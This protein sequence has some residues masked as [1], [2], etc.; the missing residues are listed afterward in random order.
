MEPI[1]AAANFASSAGIET[2]SNAAGMARSIADATVCAEMEGCELF[3][4]KWWGLWEIWLEP[5]DTIVTCSTLDEG[6]VVMPSEEAGEDAFESKASESKG[7]LIGVPMVGEGGGVAKCLDENLAAA[8][9]GMT[10]FT[11]DVGW[12]EWLRKPEAQGGTWV[13]PVSVGVGNCWMSFS[14]GFSMPGPAATLSGDNA[15]CV[16]GGGRL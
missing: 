9:E 13:D 4:Y 16:Y 10:G 11:G 12:N 5:A 14:D 1:V 7:P 3:A 15:V 6:G 2:L 8:R